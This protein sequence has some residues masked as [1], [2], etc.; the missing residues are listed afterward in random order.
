MLL[1]ISVLLVINSCIEAYYRIE[2]YM[3]L[4]RKYNKYKTSLCY[5]LNSIQQS[6]IISR[7]SKKRQGVK[8]KLRLKLSAS[9]SFIPRNVDSNFVAKWQSKGDHY[10]SYDNLHN[11][12][13]QLKFYD[14]S[15]TRTIIDKK[16]LFQEICLTYFARFHSIIREEYQVSIICTIIQ[17]I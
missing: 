4:Q 8:D 9:A 3:F 12:N 7:F 11:L 17:F 14:N 15:E 13:Q 5:S 10:I 1:K 6:T 2:M 16:K